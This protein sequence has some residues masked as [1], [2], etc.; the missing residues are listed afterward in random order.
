MG[1]RTLEISRPSELH[2]T[3]G[4]LLIT[5]EE[6][7][8]SIPLEDLI[9]IVCVGSNIRLSTMGMSQISETGITIMSID[10]KYK[11]VSIVTPVVS[12][13]RQAL[14]MRRQVHMNSEKAQRLWFE[15]IKRKIE[16]QARALSIL[17]IEGADRVMHYLDELNEDTV[18]YCE[19]AAAKEYF[20]FFHPG[21]NR[22]NDDPMNSQL[23]YG[24][25]VLRNAIIRSLMLAGF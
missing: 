22:R 19:A 7:E 17:G 12:N 18:D 16:N 23:N 13:A 3:K 1:F 5:Q 6:G 9:T 4:Q 25:A 8:V 14:I 21:L 24:Y 2:V 11:P 10:E 15:I 20:S